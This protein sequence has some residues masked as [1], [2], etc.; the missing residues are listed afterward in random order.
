MASNVQANQEQRSLQVA[1]APPEDPQ[2]Q[3]HDDVAKPSL[4]GVGRIV[5]HVSRLYGYS[6]VISG[7]CSMVASAVSSLP[8]TKWDEEE[9]V[10]QADVVA[11]NV[12]IA[13][14]DAV[15]VSYMRL[16]NAKVRV[17][18]ERTETHKESE[19]FSPLDDC[20]ALVPVRFQ[21]CDNRPAHKPSL[22]ALP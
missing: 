10:P 12:L 20:A 13:I 11:V 9:G 7:I 17:R 19:P 3:D 14:W 15:G 6:F 1:D 18:T 2:T 21:H 16:T 22:P 5:E 8:L 4:Y